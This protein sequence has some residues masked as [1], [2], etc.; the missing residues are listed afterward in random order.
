MAHKRVSLSLTPEVHKA[1]TDT[2][3][4]MGVSRSSLVNEMLSEGLPALAEVLR[5]VQGGAPSD[6]AMRLRGASAGVIRQ[7]LDSLRD[8]LDQLDPDAFELTL[9]DDRPAGCSCDYSTG[10][11]L[12]P[13]GGCLVHGHRG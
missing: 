4:L 12:A 7:R 6:A 1:L 10:E 8:T 11:R 5:A 2:A 13:S 9:C 3:E